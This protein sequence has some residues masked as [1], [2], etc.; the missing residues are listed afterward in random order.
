MASAPNVE[1][2]D[3]NDGGKTDTSTNQ[4]PEPERR[5]SSASNS[6][7]NSNGSGS[8]SGSSGNS[9]SN[10]NGN[11]FGNGK[12]NVTTTAKS[13]FPSNSSS[14]NSLNNLSFG[15]FSFFSKSSG[16]SSS[17][18]SASDPN[19]PAI[20]IPSPVSEAM[21]IVVQAVHEDTLGHYHLALPLYLLAIQHFQKAC[22][23]PSL[24]AAQKESIEIKTK[25]YSTRVKQLQNH[26]PFP[27]STGNNTPPLEPPPPS[28][29]IPLI[30]PAHIVSITT[31]FNGHNNSTNPPPIIERSAKSKREGRR[32]STATEEEKI[33]KKKLY[34]KQYYQKKRAQSSSSQINISSLSSNSP[35]SST[36]SSS[37][38]SST[39]SIKSSSS[40]NSPDVAASS[41][42]P[43]PSSSTQQTCSVMKLLNN[44]NEPI[45]QPESIWSQKSDAILPPL[46]SLK[47]S[48]PTSAFQQ[49]TKHSKISQSSSSNTS[50]PPA[51]RPSTFM[52]L[53]AAS[54]Q[55]AESNKSVETNKKDD[56][57]HHRTR[58]HHNKERE[59]A[60]SLIDMDPTIA[61]M[62]PTNII[63]LKQP[64]EKPDQMVALQTIAPT[65]I[66]SLAYATEDNFVGKVLDGYGPSSICYLSIAASH[67][68]QCV[69]KELE[70]FG[71]SLKVFD[72][73][74]PQK[75]VECIYQWSQDP[76]DQKMK[77]KFYPKINKSSLFELGYVARKSGHSRG[78][79][80]DLTIVTKKD[81]SNT[82]EELD[83]G[84]CFDFM[85]ELSHTLNSN[86]QGQARAN[87]M[88]LKSLME[89]NGFVNFSQEWWHYTLKNET[90]PASY[91]DFPTTIG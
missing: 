13:F 60:S 3:A 14:L 35:S 59:I 12:A 15:S 11:S 5:N 30:L 83:M 71:L 39:P 41:S 68:L 64:H 44:T 16:S 48:S 21:Q 51:A 31:S 19:E 80:V 28:L 42:S 87:R 24:D 32:R 29:S 49:L 65:I 78:S 56:D 69:Q 47:N 7:E 8:S 73:Y 81:S 25:E 22:S 46:T 36:S 26:F 43:K 2:T 40:S 72:A 89:R 57:A 86:I 62:A 90:F 27:R 66:I 91:F 82:W 58:H 34:N 61:L 4:L 33:A 10:N 70:T 85:D 53:L 20:S 6:S 74:R 23:D 79:T 37:N 54:S 38:S 63:H 77:A 17:S 9:G 18:S 84:T 88:L 55:E 67:A 45:K 75:A 1:M 76:K 50:S 52:S